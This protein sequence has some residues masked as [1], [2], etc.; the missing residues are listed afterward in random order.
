[1]QST[2]PGPQPCAW[3]SGQIFAAASASSPA[4]EA[5]LRAMAR[6][7]AFGG[8]LSVGFRMFVHVFDCLCVVF[9][10]SFFSTRFKLLP[11]GF[12]E[13][14]SM[15]NMIGENY[16]IYIYILQ[17]IS[18]IVAG[19]NCL[20][21]FLQAAHYLSM[22]QGQLSSLA[23]LDRPWLS[24][25]WRRS[26]AQEPSTCSYAAA[27]QVLKSSKCDATPIVRVHLLGGNN[28]NPKPPNWTKARINMQTSQLA[29]RPITITYN[30]KQQSIHSI[31]A[32]QTNPHRSQTIAIPHAHF[33]LAV[34]ILPSRKKK[35]LPHR[36]HP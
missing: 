20:F 17:P 13:V 2:P 7:Q 15:F 33:C 30:E 31:E 18:H 10:A 6:L 25:S 21:T 8:G 36:S 26:K 9:V 24:S 5:E 4:A 27:P 1:M 35:S 22:S 3:K 28:P 29:K 32:K 12:E 16:N 19:K 11:I 34:G 14:L 23:T